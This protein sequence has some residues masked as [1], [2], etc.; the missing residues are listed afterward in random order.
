MAGPTKGQSSIR[1]IGTGFKPPR[2]NVTAK[3]GILETDII[4]KSEVVD[5]IYQR[6]QFE[7]MIEG[8][9]G[10]KSY[11]HEAS[12]F[13]RVD[14]EMIESQTYHAIY[15]MSP[16]LTNWTRTHGG[17]YY[18]EVGKNIEIQYHSRVNI[19]INQTV[20]APN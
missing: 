20:I 9:E 7:N 19:T 18:L 15:M 17:P 11:F 1:V 5:Y 8:V 10:V 12:Q 3:W 14:F 16:N 13:A 2:S 4:V 6:L